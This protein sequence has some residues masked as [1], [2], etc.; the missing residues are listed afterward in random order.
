[1]KLKNELLLSILSGFLIGISWFSGFTFI[2]F[3][4]FVPFFFLLKSLVEKKTKRIVKFSILF[5][6]FLVWNLISTW[7]VY[8]ASPAALIAFFGN[9][10]FMSITLLLSN[11]I[12]KT[13]K[14]KN[15]SHFV[16]VPIWLSFEYLYQQTD[17]S[18]SWL[19]L[20]NSL[21]N[22]SSL[23]QWY[24]FTGASGGTAW[25]LIINI[26]IFLILKTWIFEKYWNK[27]L[28]YSGLCLFFVPVLL[29]FIL[30]FNASSRFSAFNAK[31]QSCI[32]IQPNIDPYNEKFVYSMEYQLDKFKVTLNKLDSSIIKNADYIVLP[33]TFLARE[34]WEHNLDSCNEIFNLK[35]NLQNSNTK[36]I[37]GA[38]TVKAYNYEA[39]PS[40]RKFSDGPG[41]Y[42]FFNSALQIESSGKTQIY[43]KSKLVPGVETMPFSWLLKP[44]ESVAIQLGGTFGSLGKQNERSVFF[45]KKNAIKIAPVICYESIF[46][47]Y[48]TEYVKQGANF[49]AIITN[50][51]W[52]GNTPGYR[53]HLAYA[54]L[55]AIETR[56][57]IVRS[58][59]T[60]VSCFID[61]L[62][63][64]S[65][66]TDYWKEAAIFGK[67]I[68]N[69]YQTFYVQF[70][71]FISLISLIISIILLAYFIFLVIRK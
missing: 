4:S 58:A 24:E 53:Q 31:E 69:S 3:F 2:I 57:P 56:K 68:P 66:Q 18:W 50:D 33:E 9:S 51:G 21:A 46:S 63:N 28:I 70:G 11:K 65:Q 52:W 32:L 38:T 59:N 55:R 39:T 22:I 45:D 62:G 71:D 43:H 61:P 15:I 5:F 17:L 23:A 40:A 35:S 6:G 44:L 27:K 37:C 48:V 14:F 41:Y 25:I 29:S 47:E 19:N 10:L 36:I 1:M 26:F 60:G 13:I 49:I 12:N 67:I 42:D 34:I 64:I 7:W 20:G 30:L 8:N 54:K 16:I